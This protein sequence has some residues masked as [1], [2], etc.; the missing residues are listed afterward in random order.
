M[1]H[2]LIEPGMCINVSFVFIYKKPLLKTLQASQS[3]PC[4]FKLFPPQKFFSEL[5]K[6]FYPYKDH[7]LNLKGNSKNIPLFPSTF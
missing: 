2:T 5:R 7:L 6:N 4:S 1:V 3:L